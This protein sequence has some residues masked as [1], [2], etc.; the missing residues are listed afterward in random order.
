MQG[1][2]KFRS[3]RLVDFVFGLVK[4]MLHLPDGQVK[5][6]RGNFS[7][8]LIN[9]STVNHQKKTTGLVHLGYSL[10]ERQ[11]GKLNFFVP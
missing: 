4:F 3:E 8:K 10:P 11:A 7:L 6:F 9:R 2:K 5:V 1:T